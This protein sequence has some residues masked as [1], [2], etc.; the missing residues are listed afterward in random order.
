[1]RP[2][3]SAAGLWAFKLLGFPKEIHA[4]SQLTLN[5]VDGDG[6][7]CKGQRRWARSSELKRWCSQR[8]PLH[9]RLMGMGPS[10]CDIV[11]G[12]RVCALCLPYFPLSLLCSFL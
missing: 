1:M 11:D 3:F 10:C 7:T 5:S 6:D 12:D 2:S 4:V 9:L 8:S